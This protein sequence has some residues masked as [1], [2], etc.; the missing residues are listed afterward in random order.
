MN[1]IELVTTGKTPE[2][3]EENPTHQQATLCDIP[4]NIKYYW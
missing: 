3:T 4:I 1:I 2:T